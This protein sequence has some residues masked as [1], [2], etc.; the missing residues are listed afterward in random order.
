MEFRSAMASTYTSKQISGRT[1]RSGASESMAFYMIERILELSNDNSGFL[2][3]MLSLASHGHVGTASCLGRP[4]MC[5]A[6]ESSCITACSVADQ[7]PPRVQ[8]RR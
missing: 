2:E 7:R 4:L 1:V 8:M 6:L 3:Q 5:D